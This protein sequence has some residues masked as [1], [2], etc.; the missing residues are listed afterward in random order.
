MLQKKTIFQFGASVLFCQLSS[1]CVLTNLYGHSS[2]N[3]ISDAPAA[4]EM[5]QPALRVILWHTDETTHCL[6]VHAWTAGTTRTS[7]T[8]VS[9]GWKSA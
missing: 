2:K 4:A 1:L 6:S 7:I 3:A 8:A 9:A 5:L